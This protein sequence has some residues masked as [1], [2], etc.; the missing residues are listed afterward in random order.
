MEES[1]S[2]EEEEN[3]ASDLIMATADRNALSD[4]ALR[5]S[6]EAAKKKKKKRKGLSFNSGSRRSHVSKNMSNLPT[7][8]GDYSWLENTEYNLALIQE[9]RLRILE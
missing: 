1:E 7:Y 6:L 2:E 9:E 4:S 3:D 5:E 8:L